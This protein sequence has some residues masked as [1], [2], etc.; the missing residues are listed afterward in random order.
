MES[1]CQ[2]TKDQSKIKQPIIMMSG[3]GTIDTAIEAT[4]N[5]AF[6]F[7]EKPISLHKVLKVLNDAINE[8]L[9]FDT[10]SIEFLKNNKDKELFNLFKKLD[11]KKIII[12]KLIVKRALYSFLSSNKDQVFKIDQSSIKKLITA[13]LFRGKEKFF[14]NFEN[15]SDYNEMPYQYSDH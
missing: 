14:N 7:I 13:N 2:R 9:D 6:D 15:F 3:H 5:G 12:F 4:K 8:S 11:E 1:L 10:L